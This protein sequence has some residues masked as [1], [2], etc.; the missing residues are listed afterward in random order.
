MTR[1]YA[2]V[3]APG[4]QSACAHQRST[5][6]PTRSRQDH[7]VFLAQVAIE[8]AHSGEVGQGAPGVFHH[9]DQL[10]AEILHHRPVHLNHLLGGHICSL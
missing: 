4:V 10:N 8:K 2:N 9:L 5:P 1:R 6:V 7:H 3:S